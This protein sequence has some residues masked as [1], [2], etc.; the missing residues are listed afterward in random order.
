MEHSTEIS[1]LFKMRTFLDFWLIADASTGIEE[2]F[3]PFFEIILSEICFVFNIH[4]TSLC[5]RQ[6]GV[7]R[8]H[9]FPIAG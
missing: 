7:E 9:D 8:E 6:P 4:A 2:I 1:N 5:I 3:V